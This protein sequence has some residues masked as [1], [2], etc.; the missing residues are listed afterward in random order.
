MVII[1]IK[2]VRTQIFIPQSCLIISAP[3]SASIYVGAFVWAAGISGMTDASITLN[4][5]TPYT[6]SLGSTTA[7]LSSSGPILHVPV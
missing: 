3:F 6:L 4:P 5:S 7:D 2:S 1:P